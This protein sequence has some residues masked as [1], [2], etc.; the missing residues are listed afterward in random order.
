MTRSQ[1][2]GKKLPK[3]KKQLKEEI[4]QPECKQNDNSKVK[5][6]GIEAG[7]EEGKEYYSRNLSPVR[8]T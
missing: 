6:K 7:R 2:H 4:N 5:E 1:E 8:F 3:K